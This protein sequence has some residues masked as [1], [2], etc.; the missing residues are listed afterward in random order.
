MIL[1]R[2][3]V[4][5]GDEVTVSEDALQPV[6]AVTPHCPLLLLPPLAGPGT[7]VV[8]NYYIS[9]PL[10]GHV[11]SRHTRRKRNRTGRWSSD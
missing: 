10:A 3:K 9:A 6:Q 11:A 2:F 4:P 8:R 1:E 5:A 7:P